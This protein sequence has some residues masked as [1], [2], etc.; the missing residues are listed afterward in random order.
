VSNKIKQ[1]FS[2]PLSAFYRFLTENQN[3]FNMSA[4]T[5]LIVI[6]ANYYIYSY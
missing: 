6:R 3:F 2:L 1:I 5:A 4:H